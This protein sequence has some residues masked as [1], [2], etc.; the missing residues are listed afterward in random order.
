MVPQMEDWISDNTHFTPKKKKKKLSPYSTRRNSIETMQAWRK[1]L[2]IE[3]VQDIQNV[4]SEAMDYFGYKAVSD[5]DQLMNF[6]ITLL[7]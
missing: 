4:C 3:Q 2:S 6:N 5:I 7:K 1:H